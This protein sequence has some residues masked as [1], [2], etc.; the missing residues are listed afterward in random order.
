[1]TVACNACCVGLAGLEWTTKAGSA[2]CRPGAADEAGLRISPIASR[3]LL[4]ACAALLVGGCAGLVPAA[5]Y[6]R[7]ESAAFPDPEATEIGRSFAAASRERAGQSAFRLL[8]AGLDGFATRMQMANAAERTL[9]L[10]YFII[11]QD[12]TG[13]LLTSALLRAADRGVRVR[14]LIDDSNALERDAAIHAMAAHPDIQIRRFNPYFYR[15]DVGAI[16][17]LEFVLNSA[18]LDYRMHNKLFV[19]DSSIALAGGRNIGDEYFQDGGEFDF[20]DYDIFSAGPVVMKLAEQFDIYWNNPLSIPVEALNNGKPTAEALDTFRKALAEDHKR[21]VD[22]DFVRRQLS[23]EPLAGMLSGKSPLVWANSAV[24]FD[25]PEK[26]KVEK[27]E[28]VG[29]LMH[30]SMVKAAATSSSEVVIVSPYLVPGPEGLALLKGLREQNVRVRILTN[31]MQS[32][33]VKLA[34]AAYMHY[35]PELVDGGVELFEVRPVLGNPAGSGGKIQTGSSGRCALHAKVF[36][37]DRQMVF[38][39]SMNFDQRSL[40]LNTELG[41]MIDSPELAQ[42]V[43]ARFDAIA[44]PANSYQLVNRPD[45]VSSARRLVWRTEENQ[46]LVEL[47]QEPAESAWQRISVNF[48]S[49]LPLDSEL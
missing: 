25:S 45:N 47:G 26:S 7:I 22:T 36:V 48:Y 17:N 28:I 10:Q 29:R 2:E 41:L 46:T 30:R 15:G 8:P 27:G 31:S 49:W 12:D 34:Q 16:R 11:Q 9:D 6:P 44:Q 5:S 18:R 23:G 24:V 38:I 40:H 39:G 3:I 37:F 33:D 35:R 4:V 14:I 42:Q 20:G 19:V 43:V 1:M 21:F 32:N 13:R